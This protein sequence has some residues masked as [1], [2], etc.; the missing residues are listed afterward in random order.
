MQYR[1]DS[2]SGNKL[3]ALGFGCMRFSGSLGRIDYGKAEALLLEA[4]RQG[5]NYYDTAYLYPGS[6]AVLGE[7]LEKH[8]IR[9]EVFIATKLPQGN[10]KAEEDFERFF[11]IQKKRLRTH[12]IDYYLMHNISSYA[13]WENLCGLNIKT[14]IAEKKKTG[15]I[16]QIGF[17]F[18]GSQDD[19]SR[20]L[21]AYDWD[22]CQIQYNYINVNYQAGKK[23]LQQAA[24]KGLPVFIMEPLLGGKLAVGLPK[25]A[26]TV[27]KQ[28]NADLSPVGW[29]FNWL[30]NQPEVTL[31]LSGMNDPSQLAEN[32]RLA[33]QAIPGMLGDPELKVIQAVVAEFNKSYKIPCTGCNYC[34]P[35]PQGINIPACFAAYNTSYAIGRGSGFYHYVLSCGGLTD[36]PHFSSSCVSCGKCQKNCPQRIPISES[37]KLVQKRLQPFFLPAVLKL[38]SRIRH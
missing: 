6:E 21:D 9:E 36:H 25:E 17:S 34:M 10:C 23:G 29:A 33:D 5:V 31:L 22:F 12:Y 19:F 2:K 16:R 30:W 32:V 24:A 8:K 7:V 37:L 20:M 27:F 26:E 14:W 38:A 35:C 3:S 13:Q 18:H 4:Y 1:M 28:A 11:M 15:E